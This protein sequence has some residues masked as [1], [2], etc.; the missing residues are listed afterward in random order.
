M[1]EKGKVNS[2]DL[3]SEADLIFKKLRFYWNN[4]KIR[5][6]SAVS[7]SGMMNY[8]TK[9]FNCCGK[10]SSENQD[11]R[12]D[13]ETK[14]PKTSFQHDLNLDEFLVIKKEKKEDKKKPSLDTGIIKSEKISRQTSREKSCENNGKTK[15]WKNSSEQPNLFEVLTPKSNKQIG[16]DDK[17]KT[18]KEVE[19]DAKNI[20]NLAPLKQTE[21]ADELRM[22][23]EM[24]RQES[25][26]PEPDGKAE[27]NPME[28]GMM[29]DKASG[30][31]VR[32][33]PFQQSNGSHPLESPRLKH[34]RTPSFGHHD[35]QGEHYSG[36]NS[37][38]F[39]GQNSN[40]GFFNSI[41][42]PQ[43]L[44]KDLDDENEILQ[45][46]S[47]Y[48]LKSSFG[49]V[50]IKPPNRFSGSQSLL[51]NQIIIINKIQR[52]DDSSKEPLDSITP[53][54]VAPRKNSSRGDLNSTPIL[55]K[56][57]PCSNPLK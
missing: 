20:R 22:R 35:S 47:R 43:K 28:N 34:L 13:L 37:P 39:G 14:K 7:S 24:N 30:S 32:K 23:A 56:S 10:D 45:N 8:I 19:E 4:L 2:A 6:A 54:G 41:Q 57:T 55:R 36:E 49:E 9:V 12:L 1:K 21:R 26:G 38:C 25:K 29:K 51:Q 44:S 18:I 17:L 40:S 16:D 5:K 31:S 53:K 42:V 27:A 52:A 48:G 3:R 11:A 50:P 46:S 33:E 15:E